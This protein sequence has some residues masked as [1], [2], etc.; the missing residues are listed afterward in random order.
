MFKTKFILAT[1]CALMFLQAHAQDVTIGAVA[2]DAPIE[3]IKRMTPLTEYIAQ[4]TGYKVQFRPAP[5]LDSAIEDLGKNIVQITYMTPVAYINAHEK[6]QVLPLVAPLTRGKATFNLVVAVRK[7][8]PIK[9]LEELKGKR[10]AF[11]DPKALLQSAVLLE[12]GIKKEDFSEMAYLKHYDN[13][14]KAIIMDDFDGGILKDSV[15]EK[16]AP[17]G[18]RI[19]YTSP[20]LASYV[21]V[22]N[23]TV[24]SKTQAKL[25]DAFMSL[26]NQTAEAKSIVQALDQGYDGFQPASDKDYDGERKLIARVKK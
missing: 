16:F 26:N 1:A 24:D 13:I 21:F 11:G 7:D 15:F 19:V 23:G 12:A 20:P 18:L 2:M 10:F 5:S 22:V 3:M 8:S 6:Y 9:K 17:Q 4:Q 25:T 14:A